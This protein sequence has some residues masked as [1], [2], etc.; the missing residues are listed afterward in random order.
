MLD[1]VPSIAASGNARCC[2]DTNNDNYNNNNNFGNAPIASE[3]NLLVRTLTGKTHF[4][5]ANPDWNVEQLKSAIEKVDG[6][7]A[8]DQRLVLAGQNLQ[9]EDGHAL[10]EYGIQDGD[11]IVLM[12]NNN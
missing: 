4:V 8:E 3:Y 2:L 10:Q 6:C 5:D 9:T 7:P 12:K 11:K 1:M